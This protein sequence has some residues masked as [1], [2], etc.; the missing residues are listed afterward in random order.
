MKRNCV[1][2]LSFLMVFA[3]G[4]YSY[5]ADIKESSNITA[6][7]GT[8]YAAA[9]E[10]SEYFDSSVSEYN[11]DFEPEIQKDGEILVL[12]HVEYDESNEYELKYGNRAIELT[13]TK[14]VEL[15]TDA[16]ASAIDKSDISS[17]GYTYSF[18]T[19]E[20][21]VKENPD[22]KLHVAMHTYIDSE[23]TTD[24]FDKSDYPDT[25]MYICK[26]DGKM[27]ELPY[28][29]YEVIDEGWHDGY[30]L[31]GT[32]TGYDAASCSI[33]NLELELDDENIFD[34]INLKD[35][36]A[37][38]GYPTNLYEPVAADYIGDVYENAEG[39]LCRDY[40]INCRL[41]GKRYRVNYSKEIDLPLYVANITYSLSK[42]EQEEIDRMK[43]TNLVTAHA[44][45]NKLQEEK[46]EPANKEKKLTMA[47]KIAI[48]SGIIIG[49]IIGITLIIYTL[50]GGR[51]KTEI[52]SKRE[53][54]DE[55]KHM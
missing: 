52:M 16:D 19:C 4:I 21:K 11:M 42:Q 6:K 46:L 7:D 32:I 50:R 44:F 35:L 36:T 12:D 33:G 27:Y 47:E 37:E 41:Y 14:T 20:I 40:I 23:I 28:S 38:L 45:Y 39:I 13:K 10:C 29:G 31:Y 3:T 55:L 17:G 9:Y 43:N 34:K 1:L 8:K 25:D 2:S 18:K 15:A 51:K 24:D 22:D 5:A 53:A 48:G 54:K 26:E 49:L 30:K